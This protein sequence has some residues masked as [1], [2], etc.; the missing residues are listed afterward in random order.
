[1]QKAQACCIARTGNQICSCDPKLSS[2]ILSI[3][4]CDINNQKILCPGNSWL[5]VSIWNDTYTYKVLMNFPLHYYLPRSSNLNSS[6][7]NSQCQGLEYSYLILYNTI[8]LGTC[9]EGC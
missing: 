7:P 1:M 5:A 8:P 6:T 2:S 3:T 4:E 9:R